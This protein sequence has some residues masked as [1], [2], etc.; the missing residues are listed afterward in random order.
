MLKS[1]LRVSSLLIV[2]VAMLLTLIT[3]S[4]H[5]QSS[6]LAPY[7]DCFGT[8]SVIPVNRGYAFHGQTKC[9]STHDSFTVEAC[10]QGNYSG[11]SPS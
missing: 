8:T 11:M 3:P 4:V 2:L 6:Y 9:Y 5:A 1:T 10:F 7:E